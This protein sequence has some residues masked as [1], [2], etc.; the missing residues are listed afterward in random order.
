MAPPHPSPL[1]A[2]LL[3]VDGITS[4][5]Y[6][7]DL[8]TVMKAPGA[9]WAHVRPEVFSL[10]T[11]AVT[12]GKQIVNTIEDKST[13]ASQEEGTKIRLNNEEDSEVVGMI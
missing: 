10:I 13:E 7:L 6:G 12:S 8:F 9:I 3:N 4:I 1:A 2:R 11:E 5:C